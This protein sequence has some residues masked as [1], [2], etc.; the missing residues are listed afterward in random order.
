MAAPVLSRWQIEDL[1]N[2]EE[3]V[4]FDLER[5]KT[6]VRYKG[7]AFLFQFGSETYALS[8]RDLPSVDEESCEVYVYVDGS[9]RELSI[10]SS[11]FYKLC[12]FKRG[13]APTLMIDG[14]TM[15]SV[16]ENPLEVTRRK[17][18]N[19]HGQ[20]FECCTGLGYTTIE[21]LR[22]GARRVVTVELDLNVLT[23]ASFNP[24]SRELWSPSV[25]LIVG[26]CM[27]V[28]EAMRH[29]VFDY[30]I[31]DPPRLSYATQRLYSEKLYREFYRILKRR[32]GL[33][34]YVSQSGS[35]YRGLDPARGVVE[36]LR[37]VGFEVEKSVEGV[38]VY[39]KRR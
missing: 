14:I 2:R 6:Y 28:A 4:S 13:W 26:D 31:H 33:F 19:A 23:L 15:H 1:I 38:G 8:L 5:S 17:I 16:L 10:A 20:V 30:V 25:D 11:R 3:Y 9:W 34:H 12:V 37:K 39:A 24:Y 27:T 29:S 7:D 18:K 35:K 22:R 32:G 36:R 21:A